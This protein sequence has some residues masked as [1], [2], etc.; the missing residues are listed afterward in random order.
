MPLNMAR[1]LVGA[2]SFMM[3]AVPAVL[4]LGAGIAAATTTCPT[5]L[6]QSGNW[7][8]YVGINDTWTHVAVRS[9]GQRRG[10]PWPGLVLRVCP[11]HA[12]TAVKWCG[13]ADVT[14]RAA[15]HA[16]G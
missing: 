2:C 16:E 1:P 15:A 9:E 3:I 7:V 6:R 12:C 14:M 11:F 10:V 8:G 13:L 5:Q 4:S